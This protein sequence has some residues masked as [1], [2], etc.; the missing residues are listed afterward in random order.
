[1]KDNQGQWLTSMEDIAN[2]GVVSFQ[3]QM[4]GDHISSSDEM[5]NNIPSIVID[6]QDKFLTAFPSVD[7]V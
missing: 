4:N 5:L 1:M 6:T 7:E 3:E 2:K